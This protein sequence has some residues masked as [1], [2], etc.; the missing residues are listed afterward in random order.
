[1]VALHR[2]A[3]SHEFTDTA[4][5]IP[6]FPYGNTANIEL[7]DRTTRPFTSQKNFIFLFLFLLSPENIR[8]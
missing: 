3:L 1:M 7:N 5:H 8:A 4:H 6:R 2:L